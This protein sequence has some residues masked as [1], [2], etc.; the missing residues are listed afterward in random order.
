MN[1]FLKDQYAKKIVSREILQN[2]LSN[3]IHHN[4]NL[5]RSF[6]FDSFKE[7]MDFVNFSNEYVT[8]NSLNV[9]M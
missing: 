1:T 4:N 9:K 6:R 8:K 7:A 5:S 2:T 3:W